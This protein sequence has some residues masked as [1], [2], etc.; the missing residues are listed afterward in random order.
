MKRKIRV[1]WVGII[2]GLA[3]LALNGCGENG[4]NP[5]ET[6]VIEY[7]KGSEQEGAGQTSDSADGA[8]QNGASAGG[9]EQAG[10]AGQESASAGSAGQT[11]GEQSGGQAIASQPQVPGSAGE[12][13]RLAFDADTSA[14][15]DSYQISDLLYGIFLEDIN[16]AV[17]GGLYAEMVKN[18]SFEFGAYAS[19]ANQHG[20]SV[21]DRD[22]VSFEVA[23]G[24]GDGTAIHANNPHYAVVK[25]SGAEPAGISNGGFLDGM[26]VTGGA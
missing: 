19:G 1:S 13:I 15:N 23:D 22:A 7:L 17:D 2:A 4:Q 25:N 24:S 9:T 16:Y 14:L 18:R 3:A 21:T 12:N 26:A 11:G 10:G 20:W 8:G 6:A 5:T